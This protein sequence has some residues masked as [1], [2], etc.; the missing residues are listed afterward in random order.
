MITVSKSIR[1]RILLVCFWIRIFSSCVQ[2]DISRAPSLV[3]YRVE[4]SKIKFVSMHG[5]VISSIYQTAQQKRL[6]C[7]GLASY[8]GEMK[9]MQGGG[10]QLPTRSL[11]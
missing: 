5:L 11:K 9:K 8:P 3:R 4:H 2:L 7:N 1:N 6:P 10:G